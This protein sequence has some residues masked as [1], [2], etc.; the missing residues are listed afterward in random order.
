MGDSM[1][2]IVKFTSIQRELK[3]IES[4]L[5]NLSVETYELFNKIETMKPDRD[6][7]AT[8]IM[9]RFTRLARKSPLVSTTLADEDIKIRNT[10]IASLAH[11]V[12][13]SSMDNE[14]AILYVCRRAIGMDV[15]DS[16]E[17]LYGLAYKFSFDN[18]EDWERSIKEYKYAF[19]TDALVASLLSMGERKNLLQH[20]SELAGILNCDAQDLHIISE[21]AK[22]VAQGS[23]DNL[24]GLAFSGKNRYA[25]KFNDF[26]SKSWLQNERKLCDLGFSSSRMS[27]ETIE[28]DEI[29]PTFW[30]RTNRKVTKVF[31]VPSTMQIKVTKGAGDMVVADE[32]IAEYKSKKLVCATNGGA[33]Y[34]VDGW[35]PKKVEKKETFDFRRKS[36]YLK[37]IFITSIFDDCNDFEAWLD[38][39]NYELYIGG[40][41]RGTINLY[42]K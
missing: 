6:N 18:I 28:E 1:D 13:N 19:F 41:E 30:S 37:M 15:V 38:G 2:E 7:E 34:V 21:V 40:M 5:K 42:K 25:G 9:E 36:E 26:I 27:Y 20:I 3:Q 4:K 29:F 11:V 23:F 8:E 16:A 33:I 12:L 35:M 39:C 24:S 31:N 32:V 22:S 17:Q 10:Y 14:Q